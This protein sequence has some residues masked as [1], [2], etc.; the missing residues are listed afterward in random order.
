[1]AWDLGF[2]LHGFHSG[3]IRD[4]IETRGNKNKRTL[5]EG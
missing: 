1:M 4:I 3:V 2:S 5:T